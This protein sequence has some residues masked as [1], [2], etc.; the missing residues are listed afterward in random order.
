MKII[1]ASVL[2]GALVAMTGCQNMGMMKDHGMMGSMHHMKLTDPQ[3]VAVVST[4]NMGEI[5]HGQIALQKAQMPQVRAFAQKM[6]TDHTANEQQGQALA[7][8]LGITPQQNDVSMMLKK[9]GDEAMMKLNQAS[10]Q[11]FDKTYIKSQVK[12]HK[13]VLETLDKKLIPSAQNAELK[14]M[15]VQTR[16]AVAMHLQMAEQLHAAMK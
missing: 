15:L 13:M 5:S 14:S 10:A 12:I 8:R 3:I 11:D 9:D 2:M 16:G 1:A 6:V 7:S 4:A